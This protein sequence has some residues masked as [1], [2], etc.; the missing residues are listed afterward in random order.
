MSREDILQ[1]YF[2]KMLFHSDIFNKSYRE[3]THRVLH[4]TLTCGLSDV[5]SPQWGVHRFTQHILCQWGDHMES[6]L[7]FGRHAHLGRF[8]LNQ[9][10]VGCASRALGFGGELTYP[11]KCST[12]WN[13]VKGIHRP[14]VDPLTKGKYSGCL[15]FSLMLSCK[16]Y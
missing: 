13:S 15:M 16:T 11:F 5:W 7:L 14:L 8:L 3:C 1:N 2:S 10:T 4:C 12:Y 9:M 6:K